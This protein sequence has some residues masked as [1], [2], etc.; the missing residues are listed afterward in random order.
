MEVGP[1]V[2]YMA[3]SSGAFMRGN[4]ITAKYQFEGMRNTLAA[5]LSIDALRSRPEP[6]WMQNGVQ[7]ARQV[8]AQ[9]TLAM[10]N[11]MPQVTA[12]KAD[13]QHLADAHPA[14]AAA[15]F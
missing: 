3:V 11:A 6:S 1:R 4:L 7:G 12:V 5:T 10:A 15:G 14:L 13:L 8:S 9:K 2:R